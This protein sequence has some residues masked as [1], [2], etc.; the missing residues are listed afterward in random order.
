MLFYS[1]LHDYRGTCELKGILC[2]ICNKYQ[3]D[4][5]DLKIHKEDFHGGEK[6]C[7]Q[8]GEN[9][10]NPNLLKKH[11]REKHDPKIEKRS[12]KIC[13]YL[14]TNNGGRVSA[15]RGAGPKA[16]QYHMLQKHPD[17]SRLLCRICDKLQGNLNGL[18]LHFRYFM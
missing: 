2:E 9:F 14:P 8:C 1:Y 6:I 15:T 11:L 17:P 18:Y 4:E 3:F 13:G 7:E 5:V 10:E 12:C 16:M